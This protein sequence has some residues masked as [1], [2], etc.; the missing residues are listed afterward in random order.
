[1][2]NNVIP[3]KQKKNLGKRVIFVLRFNDAQMDEQTQMKF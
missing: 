3:K 1:M 2:K